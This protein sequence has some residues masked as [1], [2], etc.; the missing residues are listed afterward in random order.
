M[1]APLGILFPGQGAQYVGMGKA[2]YDGSA[3][4]RAMLDEA[5]RVLG[6]GF[7]NIL[8]NG[9]A[10]ALTATDVSQP[11]IYAV[12]CAAFA[13]FRELHPQAVIGAAAGLSLG[14]YSALT[15]AGALPF[16][17]GI[18][19]VRQ[20]GKFMQEA[21]QATAGTMASVLNLDADKISTICAGIPGA[22][23]ANYN[24]PGQV[25]ISGT[26]DA[27]KQAGAA[28]TAAGAKRVIPLQVSGAFHS[29]LM[30]AAQ[31]RLQPLLEAVAWR[32]PAFP[33]LANVN[34]TPYRAAADMP[35]TLAR[36]V[37]ESV[38]W[39]D[40]CRWMLLQ[41][42]TTF[43][44]LGPGKVLQGLL[45]KIEPAAQCL[46]AEAPDDIRALTFA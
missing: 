39:E 44:E 27:I 43:V 1:T 3:T 37:T 29:P 34:G 30:A 26:A 16:A 2:L 45:K 6:G 33:V 4:A 8:F 41:G 12:S 11:A 32:A 35:A 10:D 15:A 25:V 31:A 17:D 24:C 7:L 40:D 18:L 13:V 46:S 20:R 9:P 5:E 38:R 19:L 22:H 42:M 14:E 23:V 28:C 36:Q 21:A